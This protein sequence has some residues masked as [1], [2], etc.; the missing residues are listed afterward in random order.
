MLPH[1]ESKSM[2]LCLITFSKHMYMKNDGGFGWQKKELSSETNKNRLAHYILID[3]STSGI[4]CEVDTVISLHRSMEFFERAFKDKRGIVIGEHQLKYQIA[5]VPK[6]IVI[7][8]KMTSEIDGLEP[9][10][11]GKEMDIYTPT[12]GFAMGAAISLVKSVERRIKDFIFMAELEDKRLVFCQN[13]LLELSLMLTEDM[14]MR[15][16]Y[17]L[18]VESHQDD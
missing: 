17:V 1:T 7:T 6:D 16:M 5:G 3:E 14:N 2:H 12:S 11:R 10:L 15:S 9:Y 13:Q 4:Y 8:K 18:Y